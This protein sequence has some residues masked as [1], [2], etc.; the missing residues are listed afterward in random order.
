[1]F[2]FLAA[3]WGWLLL[4]LGLLGL[5]VFVLVILGSNSRQEIEMY[6]RRTEDLP[7]DFDYG[8]IVGDSKRIPKE[9]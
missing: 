7:P 1:M 3:H 5:L 2:E 8:Q 4:G 9:D 6:G